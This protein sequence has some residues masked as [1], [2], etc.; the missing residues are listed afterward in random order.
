MTTPGPERRRLGTAGEAHARRF[1]EVRD[2][3]FV[4]AQWRGAGCELDLVMWDG[5]E[6]VFIEVKTRR[7]ESHGRAAESVTT[8]QA[9][10]LI[11][12]AEAFVQA[13]EAAGGREPVWRIDLVA[14]TLDRSG[15]IADVM[16]VENAFVTDV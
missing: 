2:F 4:A 15:R 11:R 7:G 8:R 6:L 10:A 12:G 5:D 13:F 1:L 16:H 3:R 14:V 9:K